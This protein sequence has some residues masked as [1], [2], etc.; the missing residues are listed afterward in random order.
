MSYVM[1]DYAQAIETYQKVI[2]QEPAVHVAWTTLATCHQELGNDEKALQCEMMAAHL[3]PTNDVWKDLGAKSRSA[4]AS[5][6][7]SGEI[8]TR[9]DLTCFLLPLLCSRAAGTME[10]AIYCYRKAIACNHDD[11]DAIWDHAYLLRETGQHAKVRP[12]SPLPH[13]RHPSSDPSC[14]RLRSLQAIEGFQTILKENPNDIAVISEM[15]NSF[16][17]ASLLPLGQRLI[18]NAL[19]RQ[20]KDYP[21]PADPF[22]PLPPEVTLFPVALLV[23]MFDILIATE[24][25]GKAIMETKK[26]VRWL[27]GR[28]KENR[29]DKVT[30]DREFDEE[31]VR[32]VSHGDDPAGEGRAA[33]GY[34]LDINLRQRLGLARLNLGDVDEARVSRFDPVPGRSRVAVADV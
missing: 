13:F 9:Q 12:R 32:R 20:Q 21:D 4:R 26:A 23:K 16:V 34:P 1:Q 22:H 30:D 19:H 17:E 8:G 31:G 24:Q 5:Q 25:W 7:V 15:S 33:E 6:I 18:L 27:G 10:Q 2:M 3:R 14:P 29:W 28:L 11:I